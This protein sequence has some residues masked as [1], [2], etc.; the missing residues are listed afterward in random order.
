MCAT[1]QYQGVHSRAPACACATGHNVFL[2]PGHNPY[3]PLAPLWVARL[4]RAKN[5]NCNCVTVLEATHTA[6]PTPSLHRK[7]ERLQEQL[8]SCSRGLRST[9]CGHNHTHSTQE[10]GRLVRAN[11]MHFA[12]VHGRCQR[13]TPLPTQHAPPLC[14]TG[15]L[16]I[17]TGKS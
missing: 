10:A 11:P 7:L 12:G 15:S 5:C 17:C 9:G 1:A 13:V 6:C 4:C 2:P 16:R 8:P 3:E 14:F